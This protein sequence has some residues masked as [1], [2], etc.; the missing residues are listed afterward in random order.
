MMR[1]KKKIEWYTSKTT[2]YQV[3]RSGLE[4]AFASKDNKQVCPFVY[5][6]DF[7]QDAIQGNLHKIKRKIFGFTYDPEKHHSLYDKQT[8]L[9]VTCAR[10]AQF[11]RKIACCV[12]F[13]NQIE[14]QLR[15]KS[16]IA[17]ECAN[18][19]AQYA[20][21]GVWLLEGSRR[22][23]ISP[24]MISMYA[25]LLRI[26]FVHNIGQSYEDTITAVVNKK[27]TPYQNKDRKQLIDALAGIRRILRHGDR[28]IFHKD[29]KANYPAKVSVSVMHNH[30]GIIKFS[31]KET[32][33]LFPY[34]HRDAVEEI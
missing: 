15:L 32:K 14:R 13:I 23:M 33:S 7:L 3:Y 4:Y 16:T 18:P 12:D 5:C 29:M 19:P 30:L 34:W 2:L 28:K 22:W 20:I 31:Q 25:L 17:T 26:G 24:P 9:L 6:K 8:K 11:R 27:V 10:D 21:S 1:R